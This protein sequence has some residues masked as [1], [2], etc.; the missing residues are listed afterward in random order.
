MSTTTAT[1][2]DRLGHPIDVENAMAFIITRELADNLPY[3]V[4]MPYAG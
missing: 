3:L 4:N 1:P 2:V